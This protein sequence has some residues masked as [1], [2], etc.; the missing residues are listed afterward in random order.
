MIFWM[1]NPLRLNT[2]C[3]DIGYHDS[4]KL[5][6]NLAAPLAHLISK[7]L[8]TDQLHF[9]RQHHHTDENENPHEKL[10]ALSSAFV[11]FFTLN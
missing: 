10:L 3:K 6:H 2:M 7:Q 4:K 11:S 9:Q 5:R 1:L 8:E